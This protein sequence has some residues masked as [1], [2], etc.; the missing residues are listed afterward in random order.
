MQ[1]GFGGPVWHASVSMKSKLVIPNV[2]SE[3]LDRALRAIQGVGDATLGQWI[4]PSVSG[5][6]VVHVK[7]RLTDE[8]W[9]GKPWGFDLRHTEE[10]RARILAAGC[11]QQVAEWSEEW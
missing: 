2:E 9:E 3:L 1:R 10:G 11:P 8:E 6:P 7:R 5:T 4:E